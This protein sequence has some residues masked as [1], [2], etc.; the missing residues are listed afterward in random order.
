MT[1][2]LGGGSGTLARDVVLRCVISALGEVVVGE[3]P[4]VQESTRLFD[5]LG[6][7]STMA[8]D[9]LMHLED[10][11]DVVVDAETLEMSDFETVGSL[12]SFALRVGGR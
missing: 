2:E 12:V 7:D 10:E 8:L 4:P 3:L 9:L 11:L 6:L 5:E 1:T